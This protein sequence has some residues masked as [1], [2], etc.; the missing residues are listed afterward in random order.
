M[1]GPVSKFKVV[2]LGEGRVGKTSLLFRFVQ[3]KFPERQEATTSANYL[4]NKICLEDG[5]EVELF[6]WDTAGQEKFHSLSPI[7]YRGAQG[8]LLVF[9]ILNLDSLQRVDK[10]VKELRAME[11][12]QLQ[13]ILVGNKQDLGVKRAVTEEQAQGMAD[14]IGA[15]YI[16]TSAKTGHG[17]QQAFSQIAKLIVLNHPDAQINR[18]NFKGTTFPMQI[19][20]SKNQQQTRSTCC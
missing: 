5:R 15:P 19:E 14:L 13:I 3:D 20:E 16:P 8:A 11:G 6:I 4:S 17:V 18:E 7:Y 12:A 1:N 9:D 10:W 2:L